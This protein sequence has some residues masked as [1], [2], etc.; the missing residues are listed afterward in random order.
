MF[1]RSSVTAAFKHFNFVPCLFLKI[2]NHGIPKALVEAM[3]R[4]GRDF[5]HLPE[6]ERMKM[7]SDDPMKANRLSTSFNVRTEKVSNWRD[8]LRLHCYPLE[9]FIHEWP[10]NPSDFRYIKENG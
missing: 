3:L 7:Y 10:S 1:K 5:F 9:K 8:F 6:S 2:T 4:V